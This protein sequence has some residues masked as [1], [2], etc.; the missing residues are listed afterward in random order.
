MEN[1]N[2]EKTFEENIVELE[3][4]VKEL[5]TGSCSLDDAIEKFTKGMTLAKICGDKLTEATEKVNKILTE[6]GE[7]KDFTA[8]EE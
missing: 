4:I 8:P 1:E 2:K 6:N 3:A 7:L 5:E